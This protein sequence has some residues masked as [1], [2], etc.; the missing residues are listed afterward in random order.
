MESRSFGIADAVAT[1]VIA[2]VLIAFMQTLY[3]C[4]GDPSGSHRGK[5]E[6]EALKASTDAMK[7]ATAAM[8]E[9]TKAINAMQGEFEEPEGLNKKEQAELLSELGAARNTARR[10]QNGTQLRGINQGMILFAQGNNGNYPGMNSA[11][12][13]RSAMAASDM[14][15]GAAAAT[16]KDQSIALAM[17]LT[18]SFFTPD[19]LISPAETNPKIKPIGNIV[20]RLTV[21]QAHYSYAMLQ[22][23][24]PVG[25]K[26]RRNEWRNTENSQ[27]PAVSDRSKAIDPELTTLSIHT[28]ADAASWQGNIA[29]NDNHVTFEMD[30]KFE[31]RK[32]KMGTAI[33]SNAMD[34]IF[35]D[36]AA[37]TLDATT[38]VK[39]M[40]R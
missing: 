35:S 9:A 2:L 33:G 4:G 13:N 16:R 3:G 23:A 39:M 40:Y 15:Y 7:D 38:N 10:M 24:D 34:D 36:E 19:Y 12:E 18:N 17:M 29:W 21:T 32:I 5:E 8:R 11:G 26:G 30:S 22:W 37:G 28:A 14:Q 25:D 31:G 27:A 20:S 1:S 6:L